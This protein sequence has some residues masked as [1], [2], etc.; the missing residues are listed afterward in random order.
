[1]ISRSDVDKGY[2][3]LRELWDKTKGKN[4][5]PDCLPDSLYGFWHAGNSLDIFMDYLGRAKP[6]DYKKTAAQL[7]EEAVTIFKD[8]TF[9]KTTG[10]DPTQYPLDQP[11]LTGCWWDDYGWWGIA[12]L[13]AYQLTSDVRHLHVARVCWHFME[14]GGRHYAGNNPIAE[15]GGTWNHSPQDTDPGIQ[16]VV[17]N[18]VFLILSA[19]LSKQMGDKQY[20][21]GARAQYDWFDYQL[22]HGAKY[23]VDENGPTARWLIKQLP[24]PK[25][26]GFWTGVRAC[27]LAG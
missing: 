14:A 18:G 21:D 23:F 20:H 25:D 22:K 17:T 16:N 7:A 24:L 19:R 5:T 11:P 10:V 3:T 13:K 1:M 6:Q 12:F 9:D 26:D 2:E 8:M 27:S 15:K 4:G